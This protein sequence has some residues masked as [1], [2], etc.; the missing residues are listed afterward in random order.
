MLAV[1][2]VWGSELWIVNTQRYCGKKLTLRQG[3]QCSLHWHECKDETFYVHSG[4]VR[5]ELD[6]TVTTLRPGD[7]IHVSPLR[8]HR[9]G[10]I[11]DSEIFEFSTFHSDDDVVRI[12][13]SGPMSPSSSVS[14]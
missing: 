10:G 9:F 3:M 14:A 13:P 1:E 4:L 11:E 7:S 2:K 5:F 12:E 6:G 8:R